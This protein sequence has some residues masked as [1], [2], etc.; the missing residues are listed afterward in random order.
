MGSIKHKFQQDLNLDYVNWEVKT[1]FIGT[2]NPDCTESKNDAE[3]FYGRTALNMF[4]DTLGYIYEN[5]PNL[6]AFGN[7]NQWKQFCKKHKIAVTDLISEIHSL[8]LKIGVDYNNICVGFSDK[9]LEQYIDKNQIVSVKVEELI[10][11]SNK[12]KHLK[13]VYLTRKGINS[14]WNT[15][16]NPILKVCKFNNLHVKTLVT[17][18]GFNYFQFNDLFARTPENLAKLWQI[19][20]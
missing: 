18:G 1:L 20:V 16:W 3:W 2:F 15:L 7:P 13:N 11:N 19:N 14:T 4:W 9:K 17:P 5:N 8:D 12:L 10:I 6:G